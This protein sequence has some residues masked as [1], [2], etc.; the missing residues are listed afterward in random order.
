[1]SQ[2]TKFKHFYYTTLCMNPSSHEGY[3][4]IEKECDNHVLNPNESSLIESDGQSL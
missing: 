1:M 2:F 3:G 4:D